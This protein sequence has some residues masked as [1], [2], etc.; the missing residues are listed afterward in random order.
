MMAELR[1]SR[2][3]A[4]FIIATSVSLSSLVAISVHLLGDHAV[5]L[6]AGD[7]L[8][9]EVVRDEG[10]MYW[11]T[12]TASL[13]VPMILSVR[14]KRVIAWTAVIVTAIGLI[15]TM[16]RTLIAAYFFI[17]F[18][19][20]AVSKCDRLKKDA[21]IATIAI[22]GV[23][24]VAWAA[25][26]LPEAALDT[27]Q[28]RFSPTPEEFDRA[29]L[30]T[31]VHLYQQYHDRLANS[32]IL[33]QG[34]GHP[35]AEA[36]SVERQAPFTTDI[37]LLTIWIPIGIP[38]SL[39][40][41]S[42]VL[43]LFRLLRRDTSKIFRTQYSILI[44]VALAVSFNVDLWTRSV[45]VIAAAFLAASTPESIDHHRSTQSRRMRLT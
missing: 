43:A 14:G 28:A 2:T 30:N 42:F 45:F 39:C 26:V 1:L 22:I 34:L 21:I 44:F 23:L 27:A 20:I 15:L 29:F 9:T 41:L 40:M 5:I 18:A 8:Q 16:N 11:H 32:G 6:L 37:S 3:A 12:A 38:G 17:V 35:A 4:M 7:T 13:C 25:G 33:G 36:H 24:V 19:V 31:R 10:R